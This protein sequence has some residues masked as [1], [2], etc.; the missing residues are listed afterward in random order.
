MTL[1]VGWG[2][3]LAVTVSVIFLV[4]LTECPYLAADV[5][6]SL[7]RSSGGGM[8]R[9]EMRDRLVE[10]GWEKGCPL[11]LGTGRVPLLRRWMHRNAPAP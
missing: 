8:S 11:C 6:K 7:F 3:L 9:E 10:M 1:L 4:P 2:L 5:S